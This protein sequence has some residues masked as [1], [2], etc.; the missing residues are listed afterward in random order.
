MKIAVTGASGHVGNN[1]CRSLIEHN[2]Q[3]KVLINKT[4]IAIKGWSYEKVHGNI[5]DYKIVDNLVKD[6]EIVFHAAAI[7]SIGNEP[8]SLVMGVN[9]KG[10]QNVVNA[11]LK[12]KVKRL[13]YFSSIHAFHCSKSDLVLNENHP[14]AGEDDLTY[15]KSKAMG[16]K[17]VLEAFA[18]GLNVLILNPSSIVGPND[19]KPSL[20]GQMLI[21]IARGKLP[22]LIKGGFHFVDVRDVVEVAIN[23]METGRGGERYLLSSQLKSFIDIAIP[24][25]VITRKKVPILLPTFLAWLGLPFI[26]LYSFLV[27]WDIVFGRL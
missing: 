24:V 25:C 2:H 17:I 3:L 8:S 12:Y 11:C 7:I 19:F 13:I 26:F 14:L 6:C 18:R 10:T 23:A 4:D 21:K 22:F 20:I 16:E 15:S 5:L 9:T 27:G 1:L